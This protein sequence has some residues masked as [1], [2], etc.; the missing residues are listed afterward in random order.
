MRRAT[1]AN[2]ET[3][4][5]EENEG[6]EENED[7]EENEGFKGKGFCQNEKQSLRGRK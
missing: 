5:G 3:E 6:D 1:R 7:D 4:D 2:E